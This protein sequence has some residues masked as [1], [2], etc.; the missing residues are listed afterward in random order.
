MT[1]TIPETVNRYAILGATGQTGRALIDHFL[2]K[3][4]IQLG[5]FVRNAEKLNS[6]SPETTSNPRVTIHAG[7][8]TDTNLV[9]SCLRDVSV[10]FSVLATNV[11]EP[12]T[13]IAQDAAKAIC[14]ALEVLRNKHEKAKD[15]WTCP[16]V[17]VLSAAPLHP[18]LAGH[19]P[20]IVEW[21]MFTA[22]KY[23]Y[24]D[25]IAAAAY[26][27]D[28]YPWIP[29][30]IAQPGGLV[31]SQPGDPVAEVEVNEKK[32]T[33]IMSYADLARG[34]ARVADEKGRWKG[35]GVLF[36]VKPEN[37]V[38]R[39]R[40]LWNVWGYVLP[41]LVYGCFPFVYRLTHR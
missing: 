19:A 27:K 18:A 35:K 37:T 11:N 2:R 17:I 41:G 24:N 9:T 4:D 26:Y 31:A 10:V 6:Q 16:T 21:L 32:Q 40:I 22:F 14:S 3:P 13:T 20:K 23:L 39:S 38:L 33:D 29:T 25:L 15:A 36:E 12:G 1:Q 30:V 34:M 7:A 8:L 5:L 28:S